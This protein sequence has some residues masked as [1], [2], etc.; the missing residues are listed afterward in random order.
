MTSNGGLSINDLFMSG[1]EK[2]KLGLLDTATVNY[3]TSSTYII[4]DICRNGSGQSPDFPQILRVPITNDDFFI[5][6]NR[7]KISAWD[8]Y[9]LGDTTRLDPFRPTGDYG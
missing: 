8:V 7:R 3:N 6:E 4:R 1:Y 5:I 2:Y 9:M